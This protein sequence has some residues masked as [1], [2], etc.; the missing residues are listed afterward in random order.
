MRSAL[1]ITAAGRDEDEVKKGG[2]KEVRRA[3]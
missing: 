1:P 3:G 2:E